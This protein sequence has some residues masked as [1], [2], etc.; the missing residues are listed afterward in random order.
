M[1]SSRLNSTTMLMI[2]TTQRLRAL[3][4]RVEMDDFGSGYSSLNMLKEA[5][6]DRIKLDLRFLT[7][8]EE[9]MTL[10]E[11][12]GLDILDLDEI[13]DYRDSQAIEAVFHCGCKLL[14]TVHG[15]SVEDIMQKPLLQRLMQYHCFERYVI[16]DHE[17]VGHIR[18]IYD[19]RGTRLYG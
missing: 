14:A 2:R 5:P 8:P 3:G 16:L 6:V 9:T 10:F 15:S 12:G 17:Q 1:N 4:F 11:N 13:G 18:N 19:G 7:E